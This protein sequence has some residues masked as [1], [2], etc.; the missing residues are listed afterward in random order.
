MP[1]SKV[2]WYLLV[3]V[4]TF[5][6]RVEAYPY[7]TEKAQE[8]IRGLLH[9]LISRFGLPQSLQSP[10]NGPSIKAT[11]TQGMSSRGIDYHLHCAWRP[12]SSGKVEKIKSYPKKT[13]KEISQEPQLSWT[14]ALS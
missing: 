14:S 3:G 4:D 7:K 13:P 9:E 11:I 12:Q 10:D 5:T 2:F 6:N 8:I 1:E